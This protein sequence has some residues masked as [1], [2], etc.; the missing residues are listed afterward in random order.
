MDNANKYD[1]QL[2]HI[3]DKYHMRQKVFADSL[4]I[5]NIIMELFKTRCANKKTALWGAGRNNSENSHAAVI[6]NKYATYVQSLEFIIDS[7]EDFHGKSFMQLPIISPADINKYGIDI[8]IVASKSS[9]GSIKEDLKKH[10][11]GCECLDIYEE[12][13]KRDIDIY[14]KFFE[15]SSVYT[16]IFAVKQEFTKAVDLTAKQ[17]AHKTLIGLYLLIR[18][19]SYADQYIDLYANAGYEDSTEML[20]MQKEIHFLLEEIQKVNSLRT[21]DVTIFFIDSLRAMD[22]FEKQKGELSY[23]M[24]KSYLENAAVF[25]NAFSTGPTT[26]ESMMGIISKRYSFEKN[27]YENNFIFDYEEFDLLKVAEDK[28]MDVHFYISEG[29]K[30]IKD[31]ANITYKKQLYMT[32]KLWSVATDMAVSENPT[33]NFIYFPCE[34]HFPLICGDHTNKPEIKSFVDVGVADMSHFIEQQF[35][36]C[37]RYVDRV[38]EAYR[39]FFSK[40]MLSVFFSDHSQVIYDKN[41]QKPF[42]TYYNNL[43]RSVHVTF[44]ISSNKITAKEYSQFF[45]MIDF[46]SVVSGVLRDNEIKMPDREVIKY[47]YY[48]IHNKRLRQ[49]AMDHDLQDY[50]EGINCF[51]TQ[52]YLYVITGTGKEE[53][54]DLEDRKR[55]LIETEIGKEFAERIRNNYDISFPDFLKIH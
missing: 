42:F 51:M 25:T 30:V 52:E 22:V 10:A 2:N 49:Y 13:R 32:D 1:V 16:D 17:K 4:Q 3:I 29:Y 6:I 11:P 31:T 24:L 48:N 45:S 43:D 7:C 40:E 39:S 33:F 15:E 23:K 28:G 50:I 5:H 41:E 44:F 34:L 46:N 54:Y 18:N 35:E 26:Y 47:Q 9:A 53:V 37:I 20:E 27:A 19:F 12:L 38:F 14:Y 21:E 55:D 36:D 8:V